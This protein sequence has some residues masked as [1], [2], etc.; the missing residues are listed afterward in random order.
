MQLFQKKSLD[1]SE[2]YCNIYIDEQ[3]HGKTIREGLESSC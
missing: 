2:N 1:L 3:E